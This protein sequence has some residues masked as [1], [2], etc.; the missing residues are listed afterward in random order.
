M[1]VLPGQTILRLVKEGK[2]KIEPFY[3]DGIQPASYD[4]RLGYKIL[5]GPLL[6]EGG[7]YV[8]LRKEKITS[9][10]LKLDNS[11]PL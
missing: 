2:L 4:A 3:K 7:R 6:D 11:S 10:S 1:V 5:A 8:D 9:I